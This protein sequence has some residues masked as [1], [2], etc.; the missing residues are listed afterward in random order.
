M[1]AAVRTSAPCGKFRVTEDA[2]R[3][4]D[5]TSILILGKGLPPCTL[6]GSQ[7]RVLQKL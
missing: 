2:G 7:Y 4:S 1:L 5:L 6:N 3:D